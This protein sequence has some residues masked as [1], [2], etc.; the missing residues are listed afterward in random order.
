LPRNVRP[1]PLA[2][3]RGATSASRS[4]PAQG[5]GRVD[6]AAQPATRDPLFMFIIHFAH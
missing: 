5:T 2:K 3:P 4:W 1:I 6:G